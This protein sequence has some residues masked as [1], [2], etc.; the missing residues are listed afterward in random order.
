MIYFWKI[1]F[2]YLLIR[3]HVYWDDRWYLGAEFFFIVSGY[4]LAKDFFNN[5]DTPLNY[6]KKRLIKL[7]PYF[8][9]SFV[10]ALLLKERPFN[11]DNVL[12]HYKE[13]LLIHGWGFFGSN[14]PEWYNG[15]DWYLSALLGA[16]YIIYF[17]LG[18]LKNEYVRFY[19]P[20]SSILLFGYNY[21]N[22][23]GINSFGF[24]FGGHIPRALA[25]MNLGVV[26]YGIASNINCER[27]T[28]AIFCFM[29]DVRTLV[30]YNIVI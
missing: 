12:Q 16:G 13:F 26:A 2:C 14:D 22:Y 10:V 21:I 23:S 3:Y 1:V 30:R 4:L 5:H 11:I 17:L 19:A 27:L 9:I 28:V 20:V 25:S 29:V 18:K 8:I 24:P 15:P 7:Y 6:L